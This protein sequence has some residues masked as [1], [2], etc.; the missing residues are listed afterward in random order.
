MKQ[1][2]KQPPGSFLQFS[3]A[4]MCDPDHLIQDHQGALHCGECMLP[5]ERVESKELPMREQENI[6]V[7]LKLQKKMAT[8]DD[9]F[10]EY[11]ID[12]KDEEDD[13]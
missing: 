13:E 12:D 8:D 3:L 7:K 9:E 1:V 6:L 11:S 10:K 4:C 5:L 2:R